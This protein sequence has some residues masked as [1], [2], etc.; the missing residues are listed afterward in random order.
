MVDR[1]VKREGLVS[2]YV[3]RDAEEERAHGLH[4]AE[5][6]L[7]LAVVAFIVVGVMLLTGDEMRRELQ[8]IVTAFAAASAQT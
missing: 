2:A 8:Q 6:A 4:T 3:K 5:Y 7:V 1:P